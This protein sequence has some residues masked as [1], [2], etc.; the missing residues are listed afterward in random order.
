MLTS[1]DPLRAYD[2]LAEALLA[3]PGHLRLRQL[4]ALALARSGASLEANALLQRLVAEGHADEET[5]GLLAR[6]HKDLCAETADDESRRQHL[7]LAARYYGDAYESTGG[8]WSGINAAT[9]ALVGGRADAAHAFARRVDAQCRALLAQGEADHTQ[10]WLL[11]TLGEAALVLGQRSEAEAWYRRAVAARPDR[12]GDI[13]ATRRNARLILRAVGAE[14]SLVN[15]WLPVPR[16]V[17]FSGHLIDRP[18]RPTPRFPPSLEAAVRASLD[19]RLRSLGPVI[20]YSSAGCGG[21]LLFLESL[22]D[23]GAPSHI[24]LPYGTPQFLEDSVTGNADSGWGARFDRALERAT[25][26]LVASEHRIGSGS[27]SHQYGFRMLDGSA[28]VRADEL[29]TEIVCLSVWDGRP[30]DGPG[31]TADAIAHWQRAGRR[32]EIVNTDALL[33]EAGIDVRTEREAPNPARSSPKEI[34]AAPGADAAGGGFDPR[35]VGLLFADAHGF[36]RLSESELPLFV[37]HFLGLVARELARMPEAPLLANTWGDGLYVVFNSIADTGEFAL[38]LC[39]SVR[40]TD[41]LAVGLTQPLTV[42]IGLH[43]GPAYACLDP[44]TGRP[45]YIGSHVS[46]AARIEPIAPPGE[47]Y[48]SG[49]FAALARADGVTDLVCTYVGQTPLAKGYG[50]FPTYIVR[51]RGRA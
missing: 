35:I 8:Y 49:A 9:M 25:N 48:G 20:G 42:R 23:L 34:A 33:R 19:E 13:A 6:T 28:A 17:V 45:N 7:A 46:R 41:W 3:F 24:V 37:E 22:A 39:E 1:A 14:P 11:A 40:N 26:V 38:R 27:I 32:V 50:T 15:E 18:G 43:A 31:G 29:D 21:D 10:Y 5:I 16:V 44:V 36:S 2:T 30:G 12:L 4:T 51:R 47:V